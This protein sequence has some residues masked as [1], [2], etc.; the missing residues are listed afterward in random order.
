MR[1]L[2]LTSWAIAVCACHYTA[3]DQR[4]ALEPRPAS[5]VFAAS[6]VTEPTERRRLADQWARTGVAA[7]QN[8]S[9]IALP[10]S[11][12]GGFLVY[13]PTAVGLSFDAGEGQRL[14]LRVATLD[15]DHSKPDDR[16][17]RAEVFRPE[18]GGAEVDYTLLT[19][20]EPG[21]SMLEVEIP[22]RGRYVV[23]LRSASEP[24]STTL[25]HLTLELGSVLPFPIKHHDDGAIRDLFGASRD[26]GT[27]RHEGIDILARRF[28]PVLAV[29]DGVAQPSDDILGGKTVLL[30]A[31]DVSYYYA[32]LAERAIRKPTRVKAGDVL[33]Y[34]GNTG[35]AAKTPSHLHFGVF[36]ENRG[37]V[38][39]QPMLASRLL[40]AREADYFD[41]QHRSLLAQRVTLHRAPTPESRRA[42]ALHAAELSVGEGSAPSSGME[43]GEGGGPNAEGFVQRLPRLVVA[44]T[45]S[46][47]A[48]PPSF[49]L[50]QPGLETRTGGRATAAQSLSF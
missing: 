4:L 25:Y 35:N 9:E 32:H 28:T 38:D 16:A 7:L 41:P 48:H 20:L 27:R 39:P 36:R 5:R 44:Q 40:P 3:L 11:D 12:W 31:P 29:A 24:R 22:A 49:Q 15:P 46:T 43:A 8:P 47:G 33:G 45:P 10:Y 37:A 30:S 1:A 19:A 26:G 6:A 14:V 42:Q 17:I 50:P 2:T 13:E 34:V 23:R 18:N 21:Q